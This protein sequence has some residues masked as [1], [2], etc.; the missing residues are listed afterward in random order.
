MREREGLVPPRIESAADLM[1]GGMPKREKGH[2]PRSALLV[3]FGVDE[4]KAHR[5]G[6]R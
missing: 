2:G 6:L 3:G 5:W 4:G 1:Q